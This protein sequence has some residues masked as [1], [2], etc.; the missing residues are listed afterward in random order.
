MTLPDIT[1]NNRIEEGLEFY[2]LGLTV[3]AKSV[4]RLQ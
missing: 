4:S 2:I 1:I 3:I